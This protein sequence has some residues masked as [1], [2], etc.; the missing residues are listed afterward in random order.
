MKK[1]HRQN[2]LIPWRHTWWGCC[3]ALVSSSVIFWLS[4]NLVL[5]KKIAPCRPRLFLIPK[6]TNGGCFLFRTKFLLNQK[7]T[8]DNMMMMYVFKV[9]TVFIYEILPCL[10]SAGYHNL[11]LR[12]EDKISWI[13]TVNALKTYIVM[14]LALV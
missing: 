1:F 9:L 12:R 3:A 13:K 14:L 6:K 10:I 4:Q 7:S 11:I 2:R 5:V 8:E